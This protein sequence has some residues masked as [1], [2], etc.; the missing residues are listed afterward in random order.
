MRQPTTARRG[1]CPIHHAVAWPRPA[2][3]VLR[4]GARAP[5]AGAVAC[6]RRDQRLAAAGRAAHRCPPGGAGGAAVQAATSRD[7]GGSWYRKAFTVGRAALDLHDPGQLDLLRRCGPFS[8]DARVWVEGDPVP[9]IESTETLDGAPRF[10][11]RLDPVELERLRAARPG[12]PGRRQ[13]GAAPL[14]GP[15]RPLRRSAGE[16]DRVL[17]RRGGGATGR[18][19]SAWSTGGGGVGSS[20]V[21]GRQQVPSTSS[22]WSRAR[23]PGRH[24]RRPGGL[25][26]R[27][28][29]RR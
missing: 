17:V 23:G 24:G 11:Y 8:T 16:L 25:R 9:V 29:S 27:R 1:L 10:T 26:R 19:R 13:P 15:G 6:G 2:C 28:R 5:S 22:H 3:V 7:R 18:T 21:A 20:R 14:P 4:A 12:R